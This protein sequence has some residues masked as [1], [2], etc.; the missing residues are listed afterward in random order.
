MSKIFGNDFLDSLLVQAAESPRMRQN[1]D[2][3][4]SSAETVACLRGRL[5]EIIF[6]EV[7]EATDERSFREV[8]RQL[9]HPA[10]GLCGMQIPAGAWHTINVIEPS[11]I[12]EVK[13]GA[14]VPG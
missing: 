8:S 4:N 1:Y 7:Q 2:L 10:E 12:F 13:D 6:E 5:E 14:Y 3:R 9:L 11:I